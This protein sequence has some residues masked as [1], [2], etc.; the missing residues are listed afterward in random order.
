MGLAFQ[1]DEKKARTNLKDHKIS[2]EEGKTI[3]G[4]PLLWTFSDLG[5]SDTEERYISIGRSSSGQ[6]LVVVHTERE[7]QIRPISCRKATSHERRAY[8]QG[9]N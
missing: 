3:F 9:E 1:W 5:H 2:F 8:E 6:I 4:D 7:G